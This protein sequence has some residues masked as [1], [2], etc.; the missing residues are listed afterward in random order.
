MTRIEGRGLYLEIVLRDEL[1]RK[2]ES[3][4]IH[5]EN[6]DALL[7]YINSLVEKYKGFDLYSEFKW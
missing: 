3:R 6:L 7:E 5:L 2:L 4:I 1:R